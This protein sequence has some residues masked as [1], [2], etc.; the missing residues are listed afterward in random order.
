MNTIWEKVHKIAG[1]YAANTAPVLNIQGTSVADSAS[2]ADIL[3]AHFS[4]ISKGEHLSDDF[5]REKQRKVQMH[6]DFNTPL[7]ESY[8]DIFNKQEL[9]S[10]LSKCKSTT[11]GPDGIHYEMLKKLSTESIDFLLEMFNKI[12]STWQFPEVWHTATII[13]LKSQVNLEINLQIID[14]LH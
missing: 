5:L 9:E 8:N 7:Q 3:A 10:A 11:E 13:H 4:S 14:Q 6:L 12:W 1:K 2:V